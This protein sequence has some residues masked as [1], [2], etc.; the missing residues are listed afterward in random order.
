MSVGSVPVW[1]RTKGSKGSRKPSSSGKAAAPAEPLTAAGKAEAAAKATADRKRSARLQ[2]LDALRALMVLVVSFHA[3][4]ASTGDLDG[5]AFRDLSVGGVLLGNVDVLLPIFFVLSGF[6]I[7]Y[8]FAAMVLAGRP[9]PASRSWLFKRALRLLPVYFLTFLIVWVWRYGG[10]VQQWSDLAWGMLLMQTWSTDHIF[11]TIDPGWY[12][13]IEWQFAMVV[14]FAIMPFL[15]A[16]STWPQR[17]RLAAL[18]VPPIVLGAITV[19]WRLGLVKHDVPGDHWGA[20]FA[21]PSWAMMYGAGML[22]GLALV[23]RPPH[24]WRLPKP[25][26]TLIFAGSTAGLVML[27]IERGVNRFTTIW[28]FHIAIVLVMGWM[29]AAITADPDGWARR[30]LR[31]RFIQGI[32]A[33]SFVTYIVHAPV[34]RSLAAR[35]IL[36]M[37]NPHLWPF[38]AA[39]IVIIALS[40][41]WAVHRYL[42]GPLSSIEKLLAPK[43]ARVAKIVRISKPTVAAGQRL[44]ELSLRDE[45]RRSYDLGTLANGRPMLLLIYP[46][47]LVPRHPSM[48]GVGGAVRTLDGARAA[49]AG[50]SVKLATISPDAPRHVP[51][52]DDDHL[53][54]VVRLIDPGS[55]AAKAI[56]VAVAR[57]AEGRDLPERVLLV[58]DGSGFVTEIIREADPH[59]M[60]HRALAALDAQPG[61]AGRFQRRARERPAPTARAIASRPDAV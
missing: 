33:A 21:P 26:P 40:M 39:A 29:V 8:Q 22:L 24:L 18:L 14:A 49:A 55:K 57:T 15:R 17:S 46:T 44:P 12:L 50:M 38:S 4:Q 31:S 48:S 35:N 34:L 16:V 9:L 32:A 1:L 30:A 41:G 7:Y 60:L 47:G 51:G 42:E 3:Y 28:F 52:E 45:Q 37:D 25:A 23:L 36:P 27:Q 53:P 6:A 5:H 13:S 11:R 58:V 10:G 2:E 19:W 20:W 59:L 56:G 54:A 61:N 43:I